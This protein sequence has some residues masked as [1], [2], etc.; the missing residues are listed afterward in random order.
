MANNRIDKINT[1]LLKSISE[2]INNRLNDP[3]LTGIISVL[4]VNASADLKHAEV[5]ISIF[6]ADEE[7]LKTTYEILNKSAGFIRS[8]LSRDSKLRTIPQIHFKNDDSM[9]YSQKIYKII[10]ELKND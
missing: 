5:A 9:A 1:E 2:I 3:R 8:E 4:S 7:K 6:N 10:E